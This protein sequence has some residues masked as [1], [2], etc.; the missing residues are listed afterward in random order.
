MSVT[1]MGTLKNT[2]SSFLTLSETNIL[3]GDITAIVA[4]TWLEVDWPNDPR[5]LV[6]LN[7]RGT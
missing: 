3:L 7:S 6:T 2:N 5:I 1:M 4:N